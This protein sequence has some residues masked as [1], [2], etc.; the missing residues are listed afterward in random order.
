MERRNI[1]LAYYTHCETANKLIR[2]QEFWLRDC[3]LMNDSKEVVHG[4]EL[5]DKYFSD[6]NKSRKFKE[7]LNSISTGVAEKALAEF[8]KWKAVRKSETYIMSFSRHAPP[9][10]RFAHI[11]EEHGRLSMWRGYGGPQGV[12]LILK[13]PF[14]QRSNGKIMF[15]LSAVGY[16]DSVDEHLKEIAESIEAERAFL[17]TLPSDWLFNTTFLMLVMAATCLKHPGFADEDEWRLIY[18][19]STWKLDLVREEQVEIRLG[20]PEKVCKIY[21]N[22]F[23][24]AGISG[25]DPNSLI[26]RVI[27]GPGEFQ[28]EIKGY[29][30]DALKAASVSHPD[31][32]VQLSGIGSSRLLKNPSQIL[33]FSDSLGAGKHQGMWNAWH[34]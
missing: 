16:F 23:K 25:T 2:N 14:S 13:I 11:E 3:R 34:G 5:I 6:E 18:M 15:F 20:H 24:E 1:R 22:D 30:V 17:S 32:R 21:L 27:V 10:S 12:A 19:P 31:D 26:E 33:G 7:A 8:E 28:G 9:E 29:I 4:I